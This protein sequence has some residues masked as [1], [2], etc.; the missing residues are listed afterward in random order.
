[1]R[2]LGERGTHCAPL[3]ARLSLC[4]CFGCFLRY[5]SFL[6]GLF[7][8]IY[9]VAF[10]EN[11]FLGIL[12]SLVFGRLGRHSFLAYLICGVRRSGNFWVSVLSKTVAIELE[13]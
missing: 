1:V 2:R 8:G 3:I 7:W 10:R 5:Q 11:H 12:Q 4:C 6:D 9:D 13:D